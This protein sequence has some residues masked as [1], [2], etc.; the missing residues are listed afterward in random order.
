M[1]LE[2]G[3][4]TGF[5]PLTVSVTNNSASSAN[6]LSI[7]TVYNFGNGTYSVSFTATD[8]PV[9]TYKAP[10][11][12]SVMAWV[13]KGACLDSVM[14]VVV[15]DIPSSISIPNV[16]TPNNDN[17]ND[18]L[19][20]KTANM[21]EI[22]MSIFDRWGHLVYELNGA[23]AIA[24]DGKNQMGKDCAEGTYF[25]IMTGKGKDG[26]DYKDKGNITLLR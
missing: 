16:F 9:T 22:N 23:T 21:T 3:P 7:S 1:K 12:Y 13:R 10:G 8:V 15:V 18:I 20:V 17:V 4:S 5:A 26:T 14:K 2:V 19:F 6:N 11:T 24:W 25:Y